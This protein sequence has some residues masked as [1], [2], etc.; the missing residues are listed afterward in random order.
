MTSCRRARLRERFGPTRP[1]DE[2]GD[3]EYERAPANDVVGRA[4]QHVQ[5]GRRRLR[6]LGT[7][8]HPVQD[9]QHVPASA[10][11]GNHGVHFAAVEQRTHAIAVTREQPREHG[12]EL[13]RHRALF[14]LLGPEVDRGAQ[15]QQEPRGNFALLVELAHVGRLQPRGDVPVDMPDVV[16]ILVLAQIG[17]VEPVAAEQRPVIAVQQP[18]EPPDDRPLE[19]AQDAFRRSRRGHGLRAASPA[20][21]RAA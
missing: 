8:E 21:A 18:V 13:R 10:A 5:V 4:Q 12:D 7:V 20:R 19:T 3:D 16:V 17:E 9:V 1:A 2:I 15:V 14:Y 11:R 6:Q